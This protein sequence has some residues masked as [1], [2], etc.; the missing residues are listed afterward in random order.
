MTE[1]EP[2]SSPGALLQQ[3]VRE[4]LPADRVRAE[5]HEGLCVAH[6]VAE[7]GAELATLVRA[8]AAL[9]LA[10]RVKG[11]PFPEGRP[12]VVLHLARMSRILDLN[13]GSRIITVQSGVTAGTLERWLRVHGWT[14]GWYAPALDAVS[15]A[16]LLQ[17]PHP[18][19]VGLRAGTPLRAVR[20]YH[21][22][23][24]DGSEAW[25]VTGPRR[26]TGPDLLALLRGGFGFGLVTRA[27]LSVR[28][29]PAEELLWTARARNPQALADLARHVAGQPDGPDRLLLVGPDPTDDGPRWRLLAAWQEFTASAEGFSE[30]ARFR[31]L[32]A[33]LAR[34]T[35]LSEASE[36]LAPLSGL[37]F[38]AVGPATRGA[39]LT[40]LPKSRGTW[41][42]AWLTPQELRVWLAPGSA[43][44]TGRDPVRKLLAPPEDE[45]ATLLNAAL[46]RAIDPTG[47]LADPSR[48]G[49]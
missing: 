23:L 47:R 49:A 43:A 8:A 37:P 13:T 2:P 28:P 20:G 10:L 19:L 31:G 17:H 44:P 21:A 41:V 29:L 15:I 46:L 25:N 27:V 9:D 4:K 11:G 5:E 40:A 33:D 48:P 30:L 26:A 7:T 14:L 22:I 12:Y 32:Q 36:A 39:L 3:A 6:A 35:D 1:P 16:H 38:G 18:A 42:V 45:G 34:H 24:P